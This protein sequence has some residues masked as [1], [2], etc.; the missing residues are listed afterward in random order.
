MQ[1]KVKKNDKLQRFCHL[2][3]AKKCAFGSKFHFGL[4]Y[5]KKF[6][7]LCTRI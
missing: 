4:A 6:L 1:T 5:I 2:K 7:Y 3:L